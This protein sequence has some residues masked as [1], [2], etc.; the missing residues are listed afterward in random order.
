VPAAFIVRKVECI[1]HYREGEADANIAIL[2]SFREYI[3]VESSCMTLRFE[4]LCS[5]WGSL[6]ARSW[7][8]R[9]HDISDRPLAIEEERE[10]AF[11]MCVEWYRITCALLL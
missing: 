4:Q 7:W 2:P 11:K 3:T 8:L 6:R 10:F 1:S 9:V 5:H